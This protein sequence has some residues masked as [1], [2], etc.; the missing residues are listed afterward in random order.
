MAVQL[1]QLLFCGLVSL[2]G[3]GLIFMAAFDLRKANRAK[4]WPTAQGKV[5][6]SGLAAVND[7]DG[8]TYKAA[9]LYEYSVNSVD[10][11]SDVWR[12][13][14]GSSSFTKAA[15]EAVK[16]YPAGAT[17]TVYFNPENPADAMLEPGK[18]SW[19]LLF[20]GVMFAGIG[21][22]GFLHVA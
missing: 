1:G 21:A 4:T 2:A 7:S 10:H 14:A 16:R 22:I 17:V 5:L 15:T 19:S 11:R 12:V 9:I 3:L 20:G 18:V 8:T 13:R 6:S